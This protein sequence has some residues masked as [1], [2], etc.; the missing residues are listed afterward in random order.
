MIRINLIR[1]LQPSHPTAKP[2]WL[3]SGVGAILLLLVGIISGWWT[4]TLQLE[5]GALL[6]EKMMT[7]Q[8][9]SQLQETISRLSRVKTQGDGMMASLQNLQKES[10]STRNPA[11]FMD[12]VGQSL[13]NLQVWL[14]A[15]QIDGE[16]VEIHGQ[17]YLIGDV[18]T[19]LDRLEGSLPLRGLPFVEIQEGTKES[20]APYVFII[21]LSIEENSLT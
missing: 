21:R 12:I 17:A 4:H 19:C 11:D 16:T 15:I 7:A 9:L 14:D 8:R 1:Q 6:Q 5:R 2:S 10:S 18:G 13:Q 20:A 3:G